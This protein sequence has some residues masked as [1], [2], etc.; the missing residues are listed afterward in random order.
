[1]PG[2]F[3]VGISFEVMP[4][5]GIVGV[6]FESMAGVGIVPWFVRGKGVARVIVGFVGINVRIRGIG[7]GDSKNRAKNQ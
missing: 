2:I 7:E 1:M 6:S 4:R 3:V 5:V